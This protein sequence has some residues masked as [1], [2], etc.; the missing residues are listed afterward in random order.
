MYRS[1]PVD[2]NKNLLATLMDMDD[3]LLD[4]PYLGCLELYL[5]FSHLIQIPDPELVPLRM[6]LN[7]IENL[8]SALLQSSQRIK[9][10]EDNP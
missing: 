8:Q 1:H 10:L 9:L 6:R 5:L 4:A 2:R 7:R 3:I